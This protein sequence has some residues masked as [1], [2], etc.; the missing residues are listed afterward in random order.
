MAKEKMLTRESWTHVVAAWA[1]HAF[2]MTGVVWAGLATLALMNN[3]IKTMWL[4]LSVALLVDSVDGTLARKADVTKWAPNFDGRTLDNIVDYMTW[5]F[6]P[7]CFM[8]IHLPMGPAWLAMTM[9][10]LIVASSMFCYCNLALKTDDYYF[11]GFAA[12]WNIVA[13]ILWIFHTPTGF[14]VPLIIFL[15]FMTVAPITIVHPFRVG[16]LMPINIVAALSWVAMT[17]TMVFTFP[18][19]P[20][21]VEIIWWI[22]GLWLT[23][24]SLWRSLTEIRRWRNGS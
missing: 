18:E 23:F 13:V 5:T 3:E 12:M 19:R 7:A 11:M 6:I 14:N 24:M 21:V 16:T 20:L 10:V 8:Y 1:V 9:F 4:W 22:G 15:S 2:T 17:V